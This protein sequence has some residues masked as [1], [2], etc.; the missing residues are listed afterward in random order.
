MYVTTSP[1]VIF[2]TDTE[3]V[4]PFTVYS[5]LL[6]LPATMFIQS[7]GASALISVA[8]ATSISIFPVPFTMTGN[9]LMF[10]S[11]SAG[12]VSSV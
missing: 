3:T 8:A 12:D 4:L 9:V 7:S 10:E 1:E 6:N 5:S 2:L 11:V